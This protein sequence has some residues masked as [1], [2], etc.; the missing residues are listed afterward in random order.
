MSPEGNLTM[1]DG[2]VHYNKSPKAEKQ[3]AKERDNA[4]KDLEKA[5]KNPN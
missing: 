4:L 1:P 3:H 5:A 2:T